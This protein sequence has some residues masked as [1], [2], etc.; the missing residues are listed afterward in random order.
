M[1]ELVA[2]SDEAPKKKP[3]LTYLDIPG[4][5]EHIRL[6]LFIGDV[7]FEDERVSREEVIRRRAAHELPFGQV[8]ILELSDGMGPYSQSNSILRWAG[9]MS[10]L[11]PEDLQLQCDGVLEAV[12]DL[13]YKMNAWWYGA[14]CGRHPDTS[15]PAVPLNEEQKS[16]I[17]VFLNSVLL[18]ARLADFERLLQKSGGPYFCGERLTICDISFCTFAWPLQEGM[19]G[20]FAGGTIASTCLDP[21]PLL[22]ALL[23]R[24]AEHPKVSEWRAAH[25]Q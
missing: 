18:P 6:T 20:G 12:L 1:G 25:P 5:A 10:G 8:P 4:I 22:R 2:C 13:T 16:S 3:K 15:E 19:V 9:R 23:Q 17:G 11:Y 7:D 24:V 21:C 14:A